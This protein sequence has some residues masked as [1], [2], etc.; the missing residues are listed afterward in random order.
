VREKLTLNNVGR[1]AAAAVAVLAMTGCARDYNRG[2]EEEIPS[3][4]EAIDE[5]D[6]GFFS[7]VLH[8]AIA[9]PGVF[10][11]VIFNDG[12]GDDIVMYG[13]DNNGIPYTIG[14]ALTGGVIVVGAASRRRD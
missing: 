7:G 13:P 12:V 11:E 14:F 8:G 3:G 5:R 2:V 9:L 6:Y 10:G 1:G 4:S